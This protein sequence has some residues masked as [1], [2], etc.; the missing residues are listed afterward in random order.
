MNGFTCNNP[1]KFICSSYIYIYIYIYIFFF[2][3]FVL[4]DMVFKKVLQSL[5]K[6]IIIQTVMKGKNKRDVQRADEA[7]GKKNKERGYL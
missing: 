2:F 7:V 6:Y 3:S 5:F 1:L 4:F